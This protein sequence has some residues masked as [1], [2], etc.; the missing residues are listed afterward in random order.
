MK[1]I[2]I[3]ASGSGSNA[4]NIIQYFAQKP[5]FCVKSVFCNVPDAYV[6]E[7][8]KKYRIPSFVFNREEFR[9]PDKVFRQLQEQEID[10]IVLAG[11]LWLMP[12]FITAAWPNKIV[13]IHPALL[14]AY[15]GKGM[16][17]HHVHEAVIAAGEKESGITIHYVND[18]YDQGAIIFQAKCPV[19]P[20]D[21]PDDLAARV[22]ELEYRYF[23]QIIEETILK[24]EV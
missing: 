4:E 9:N 5:Q 3:F 14:P 23:P 11:F 16:Y 17:G 21:T 20:T 13:N 8:A 2:A 10:F 15:G 19:L 6:L 7:R 12:S 18:H 24:Q 22:H 1:K